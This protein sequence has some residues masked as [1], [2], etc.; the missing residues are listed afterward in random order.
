[1]TRL[2]PVAWKELVNKLKAF[3][4]EG[5][6]QAGSHPY[7]IRENQRL[8]IPNPHKSEI[9]VSLLQEILRQAGI[10]RDEWIEKR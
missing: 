6:C 2:T 4:C 10:S 1:M 9:G 3:D 7:M 8:T 5:P